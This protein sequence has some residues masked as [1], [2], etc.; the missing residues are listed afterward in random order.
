MDRL[1]LTTDDVP[2]AD[3]FSYW[4]E[5][6]CQGTLGVSGERNAEQATPFA[7]RAA[8]SISASLTCF[9]CRADG[10]PVFR[11][12]R[13]IARRSW[14]DHIWLYRENSEGTWFNYDRREFVTRRG[15]LFVADPTVPLENDARRN[16]DTDN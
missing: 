10:F 4:R 2:E 9:R 3:R 14:D 7:A 16:Y 12:P 6:L 15:D 11:R 8:V 1:V 5:A 13:D